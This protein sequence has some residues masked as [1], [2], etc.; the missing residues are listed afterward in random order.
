MLWGVV[1]LKLSRLRVKTVYETVIYSLYP[2]QKILQSEKGTWSWSTMMTPE[3]MI[4]FKIWSYPSLSILSNDIFHIH[5]Y[6]ISYWH[7]YLLTHKLML[8]HVLQI[9]NQ[10]VGVQSEGRYCW[11]GRCCSFWINYSIPIMY[12]DKSQ[13]SS[14]L[15]QARS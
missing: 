12:L 9:K 8:F 6:I 11:I 5:V 1:L 15:H 14:H 4:I 2:S 7:L 13:T 3:K 10:Q